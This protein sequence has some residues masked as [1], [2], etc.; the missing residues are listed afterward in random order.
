MKESEEGEREREKWER[1]PLAVPLDWFELGSPAGI[2]ACTSCRGVSVCVC[3]HERREG[4]GG[5]RV[6]GGG[7]TLA[8]S[9]PSVCGDSPY[10]EVQM[11][12]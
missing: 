8:G 10:N 2:Q 7:P 4:G 5:Q 1:P 9:C 3:A 6:R 12:F 11:H